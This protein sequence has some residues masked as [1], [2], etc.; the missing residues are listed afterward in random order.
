MCIR[1]RFKSKLDGI[2]HD[3]SGTGQTLFIEP[4]SIVPLNNQLKIA[5]LKVAQ[6]KARVL[7]SLALQ[8][9]QNREALQTNL[10]CLTVLDLIYSKG[11]LAKTIDAVK[12]HLN[13]E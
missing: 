10:K 13:Q 5:K 6:E 9:D 3:I 4:A 12:C 11:R 7:Q 2:V 1:D 8:T